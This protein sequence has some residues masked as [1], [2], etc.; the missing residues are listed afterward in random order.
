[1]PLETV[2]QTT[3]HAGDTLNVEAGGEFL[4]VTAVEEGE[5]ST[6]DLRADQAFALVVALLRA[7]PKRTVATTPAAIHG[8]DD[9]ERRQN[10]NQDAL[11]VAAEHDR[12]V[13]F[14][15]QKQ[16]GP[17]GII[18]SRHLIPDDIRTTREG[19]TVVSGYDEDRD[20]P[21]VFRLD[22]IVG[23]VEVLP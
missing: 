23:H 5:P 11:R 2:F 18:E 9:D 1:M 8:E 7:L 17:G 3:D 20:M 21:R 12:Q 16:S 13:K 6:V 22:R 4:C 15:Y 19:H 10:W 14:S